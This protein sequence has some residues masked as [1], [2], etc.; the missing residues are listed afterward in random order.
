MEQQQQQD[1][2]WVAIDDLPLFNWE[3]WEVVGAGQIILMDGEVQLPIVTV[4]GDGGLQATLQP[5]RGQFPYPLP[6]EAFL[7]LPTPPPQQELPEWDYAADQ[8]EV[9]SDT[10]EIVDYPTPPESPVILILCEGEE[11]N[12]QSKPDSA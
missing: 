5:E 1:A 8:W 12:T 4:G 7:P 6:V 10:T 9:A 11:S 3:G 2:I